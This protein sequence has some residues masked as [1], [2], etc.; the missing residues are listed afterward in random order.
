L[1][2]VA[3]HKLSEALSKYPSANNALIGWFQT[4]NQG[5]FYSEHSMRSTFGQMHG[6]DYQY[7]FPIPGSTL[8]IHAL[9]NFQSQVLFIDQIKPG[10]H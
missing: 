2:I 1:N 7:R 10:N 8:L 3:T 6:R 9:V 5:D 4:V